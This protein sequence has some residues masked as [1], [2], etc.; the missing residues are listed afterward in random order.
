MS[1]W[2][3]FLNL[4]LAVG[5][6]APASAEGDPDA[7]AEVFA[8]HCATCHGVGGQGDGPMSVLLAVPVPDLTGFA[9]REGGTLPVARTVSIIEGDA[10][11]RGHGSAMPVFGPITT[12]PSAVLDANDGSPVQTT[13]SVADLIAYLT[14]LQR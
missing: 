6:A 12:G 8:R 13:Q 5:A 2:I 10:V 7:G 1:R 11:L 3:L 14:A 4:A 9:E